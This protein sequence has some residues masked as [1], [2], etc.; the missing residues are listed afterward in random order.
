MMRPMP[1]WPSLEP[2]ANE[3]PVQVAMSVPRIHHG[4]GLLPFGA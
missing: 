4:G 1:F 3:T 2:W